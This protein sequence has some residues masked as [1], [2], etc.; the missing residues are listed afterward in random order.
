MLQNDRSNKIGHL[1]YCDRRPLHLALST[2]H[3]IH[4][5]PRSR[6]LHYSLFIALLTLVSLP[7]LT[8]QNQFNVGIQL[9]T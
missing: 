8:P 4:I 1:K 5:W 6:Y 9:S 7:C 2:H 3:R